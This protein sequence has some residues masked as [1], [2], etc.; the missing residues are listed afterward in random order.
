MDVHSIELRQRHDRFHDHRSIHRGPRRPYRHARHRE[1]VVVH[2]LFRRE[3]RLAGDLVRRVDAGDTAES[4]SSAATSTSSGAPF[5]I[6]MSPRTSCSGPCSSIVPRTR[7]HLSCTRWRPS[8]GPS[9]ACSR[10]CPRSAPRGSGWRCRYPRPA[11][12][13]ID[14][15]DRSLTEHLDAEE[16]H[17][18][19]RRRVAHPARVGCVGRG[20]S[21]RIR[22]VRP[23]ARARMMM[24]EGD[25]EVVAGM[26]ASA[27]ASVRVVVTC[28]LAGPSVTTP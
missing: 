8:T 4:P 9:R 24:Y 18:L 22:T 21:L 1:M 11:G 26:L 2:S 10:R 23:V 25:P 5:I 19:P 28:A 17:I 3:I 20:W 12:C 13:L 15:L 14:D 16:E 7:P 27:P 6:T